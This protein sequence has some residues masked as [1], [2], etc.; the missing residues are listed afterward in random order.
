[1]KSRSAFLKA[2]GLVD[3][4]EVD[5]PDP[6]PGSALIRVEACGICGSDLSAARAKAS[7]W[8]PFGHE[9]AGVI[10]ELG[11]HY[12]SHL[13]VGMRVVLESSSYCGHCSLCRDGRPDI[14]NKAPNIWSSPSL[15]MSDYMIAPV[16]CL[17]PYDG[18]TPAVASLAEPAGVS[19]D[20]VK[21]AEIRH[22]DRVCLLGPGPIGLMSIPLAFGSGASEVMT[23]ARPGSERR[24]EIASILHS[25][26]LVTD[27]PLSELTDLKHSFEHVLLTSPVQTIAG[28]LSLLSYGGRLTY[29]GIGDSEDSTISFDAN[30]FHFRKLQLRASYA[31]PAIYYPSVLKYLVAGIIPGELFI[32]HRFPLNDI[33]EAMHLCLTDRSTVAKV[34][35]HPGRM[36]V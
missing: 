15:G 18:L 34:V 28:A 10:E 19:L 31:S 29:I 33:K 21:T 36:N 2:P 17:V 26:T 11:P 8:I 24:M 6:P 3:L 22:G 16:E 13:Q 20:M 1:L 32:S 35:V 5:L 23:I 27:Q 9:I 30:D 4:R 25:K 7:D 12:S 14:C